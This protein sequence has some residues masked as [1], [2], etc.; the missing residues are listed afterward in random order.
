MGFCIFVFGV[1][2]C[3]SIFMYIE[4]VDHRYTKEGSNKAPMLNLTSSQ[5]PVLHI[6]ELFV[7]VSY[8]YFLCF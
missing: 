6:I 2:V 5:V 8:F 7:V 1:M 3:V 4:C